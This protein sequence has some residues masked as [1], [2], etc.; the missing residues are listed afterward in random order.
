MVLCEQW[1]QLNIFF[2]H[3][4]FIFCTQNVLACTFQCL[5]RR[6]LESR[7]KYSVRQLD[8]LHVLLVLR[9][10]ASST[11]CPWGHCLLNWLFGP[12]H[13]TAKTG[14]ISAQLS[15]LGPYPI[16]FRDNV[17]WWSRCNEASSNFSPARLGGGDYMCWEAGWFDRFLEDK[18]FCLHTPAPFPLLYG[19]LIQRVVAERFPCHFQ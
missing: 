14:D 4:F 19:P 9:T 2:F 18:H 5:R 7:K 8:Y 11:C 1:S 13:F 15:N 16:L 17:A 10:T 12:R 6:K 3:F